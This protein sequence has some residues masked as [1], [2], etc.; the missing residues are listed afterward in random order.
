MTLATYLANT[1]TTIRAFATAAGC[2]PAMVHAIIQG[3]RNAS[4]SLARSIERATGGAVKA[5]CRACGHS[6]GV[7]S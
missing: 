4:P 7:A 6:L 5:T 1:G 3:R 2:S